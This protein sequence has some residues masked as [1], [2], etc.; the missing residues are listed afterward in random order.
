M[1]VPV[2]FDQHDAAVKEVGEQLEDE[3]HSDGAVPFGA[4]AVS[5]HFRVGDGDVLAGELLLGLLLGGVMA[6]RLDR[7]NFVPV[8]VD[9]VGLPVS[10][11]RDSDKVSG[12]HGMSPLM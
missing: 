7:S 6:S 3:N 8:N 10:L 12:A 11:A 1:L 4:V 2:L 5:L 9:D